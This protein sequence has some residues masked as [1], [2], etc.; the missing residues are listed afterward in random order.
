[1]LVYIA[2]R[3]LLMIPTL[4]LISVL[5][6]TIIELPPGDYFESHVAELLAQGEKADSQ[7]IAYLRKEYGLTQVQSRSI[8]QPPG[9]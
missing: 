9:V 4:F 6:F 8:R 2:R 5:V 7:Q 1:M 3:V